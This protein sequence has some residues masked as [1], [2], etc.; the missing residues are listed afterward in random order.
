[1]TERKPPGASVGSW[2]EF[3][4]RRAQE[5]GEFDNL[6]GH[7]KPIADLHEPHDELWWV[8]R[9]LRD[10]NVSF[11]PPALALRKDVEAA[12]E[13]IAAQWSEAEVRRIVEEL[14]ARILEVNRTTTSGP[15][16]SMV[17]LDVDEVVAGWRAARDDPT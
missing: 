15:S 1:V 7:G 12:H 9:K 2:V 11:T 14:N 8:K 5:R 3:Q 13:R 10:E 16:T 4:I 17:P 6:R